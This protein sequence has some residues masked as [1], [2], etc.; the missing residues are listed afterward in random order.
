METLQLKTNKKEPSWW[1]DI[2][3]EKDGIKKEASKRYIQ[4]NMKVK[5][6]FM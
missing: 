2:V 1:N 5:D 6:Q 3:R 4:V